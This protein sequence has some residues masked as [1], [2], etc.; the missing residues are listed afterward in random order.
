MAGEAPSQDP[1]AALLATIGKKR[2]PPGKPRKRFSGPPSKL[3]I[4]MGHDCIERNWFMK[5]NDA[6]LPNS[7]TCVVCGALYERKA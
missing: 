5:T 2:E 6:L 1:V 7:L 4:G 3:E